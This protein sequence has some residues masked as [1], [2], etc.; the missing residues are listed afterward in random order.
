M[1]F[2][3]EV[4]PAPFG[5]MMARISPLRMSNETS[6]KAFT[7]PK[8]RDTF[9]TASS[10]SPFATTGESGALMASLPTSLPAGEGQGWGQ[11]RSGF[12]CHVHERCRVAGSRW[13]AIPHPGPPMR[14]G[15]PRSVD[16][17]GARHP[18]ARSRRLLQHRRRRL[19]RVGLHV[20]NLHPRRDDAFASVLEGHLGADFGLLRAVVERL[21][22]G[23]V[24][25]ADEAAADLLGAGEL[26]VVGFELLRQDQ[27]APH[28]GAT[29]AWFLG[30]LPVH[31]VDMLLDHVVDERVTGELLVRAVGD[32]VAL[33][34]VADRDEVDVDEAGNRVLAGPESHRLLDVGIEL[35]LVLD[36]FRREQ[37]AVAHPADVFCPVDDLQMP[38]LVKEAGIARAHEAVGGLRL[39]GLLRVLVVAEED[40]GRAVEDLAVVVDL[41]L[42]LRSRPSDGVGADLAVGLHGDVD[43]RLGLAVELL[44]VD[45]DGAVELED[46]RP[47]GLAGRVSD[48]NVRQAEA[49]LQRR[50]DEPIADLPEEAVPEIHPRLAIEDPLADP[51]R[52]VDEELE[53]PP[54]DRAGILHP[55]HGE[56]EHVLE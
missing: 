18:M 33:G 56:G 9:S 50:I 24:A 41:D 5:P 6:L 43:R 48:L 52:V 30:Q 36:V 1:Q 23:F 37:R 45:T 49:V 22:Q 15:R 38:G 39:G 19:D 54:L 51:V 16:D 13:R 46:L 34:P 35:Q 26:A 4:L 17:A 2:S 27:E 44:Q 29:H 11:P 25:L 20:A 7:P 47:D 12:L 40:A 31:L 42:D 8:P 55:H 14:G 53:H 10:A 28:L 32:G 21:D 3:I